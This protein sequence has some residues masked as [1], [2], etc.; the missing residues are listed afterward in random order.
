MTSKII[1]YVV[2]HNF[3]YRKLGGY[4]NNKNHKTW[5]LTDSTLIRLA[6]ANYQ[7]NKGEAI[8]K[9][10]PNP[11][12]VSNEICSQH[13]ST[14]NVKNSSALHTFFGQFIDHDI[15]LSLE[16]STPLD[17]PIPKGDK[18]FDPNKTG[19]KYFPFKRSKAVYKNGVREQ[20]NDISTYI[21]CSNVYGSTKER[22]NYI[23][24]FEKGKLKTISGNLPPINNGSQPNAN[25]GKPAGGL[26]VCGDVRANENI[27]LISIH[28]VFLRYHNY[29]ADLIYSKDS[30]LSDE[31]IY[32]KSRIIVEAT[33]QSICYNEFLDLL[34]GS[35]MKSY[36]GYN[37]NVNPSICNEFSTG[38]FR[39]HTLVPSNIKRTGHSDLTLRQVFF[40]PHIILN[41]KGVS[42]ILSGMSSVPSEKFDCT[43]NDD[44]RNFLFGNPGHGGLDLACLNIQRG[45]DHGLCKY[46]EL[47]KHFNLPEKTF[48][49]FS[50]DKKINHKLKKLYGH[51]DNCDLWVILM[52]EDKY[53]NSMLGETATYVISDQFERLRDGDRFYYYNRFPKE[54][55]EDFDKIK[56][57]HVIKLTTKVKN[58]PE[59]C[60]VL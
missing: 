56:L 4:D 3:E 8:E 28:I 43:I 58:I 54:I 33:Y 6:P 20:I 13:G 18:V 51:I 57:S 15:D 17:I 36:K 42:P 19:D 2:K 53:E 32:Q 23:R 30:K 16:G 40:E 44:L 50:K 7:D 52:C 9:D 39:L 29:C 47:R 41:E 45:R 37:K 22:S 48:D 10:R 27:V 49:N 12:T 26:F 24:S 59:N 21:D 34:L 38:C 46:N 55:C 5:G 60:M 35:Q 31:E 14:K 25:G 1:D 11:R